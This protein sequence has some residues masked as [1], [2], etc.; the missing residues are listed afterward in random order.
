MDL[1]SSKRC[2]LA[3]SGTFLSEPCY[4]SSSLIV[5]QLILEVGDTINYLHT[6]WFLGV[7]NPTSL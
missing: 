3:M 1:V 4:F 5:D 6:L 7:S 2:G